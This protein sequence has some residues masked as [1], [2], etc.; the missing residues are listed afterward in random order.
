ME[1]KFY[2]DHV[3]WPSSLKGTRLLRGADCARDYLALT[4]TVVI[5]NEEVTRKGD[6]EKSSYRNNRNGV[7][8]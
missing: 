4:G 7:I 5:R 3:R 1:L 2:L 8:T 6:Y